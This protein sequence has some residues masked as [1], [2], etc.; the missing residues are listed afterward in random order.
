MMENPEEFNQQ[1]VAEET[2]N[3]HVYWAVGAGLIP[4]PFVDIAAVTAI[5][6]DMLKS[7]CEI[8]EVE[9][10]TEQGKGWIGALATSTLSSIFAKMGASTLKAIPLIGQAVGMASMAILSGAS[11]YALGYVFVNHF[12]GGGTL[13][14]FD[15][16]KV[17]QYYLQKVEEGKEVATELKNKYA[18]FSATEEGE[19]K[20]K[21][22]AKKLKKL[23]KLRKKELISEA[24]YTSMRQEV[25]QSLLNDD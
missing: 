21:S 12:E 24:E 14:N 19:E 18:N 1:E 2:I 6:L 25:L 7:I 3:R 8:Y 11:T 9:Y 10:S 15:A 4:V 5:Q 23:E 16:D 22:A 17:K 20:E 13:N